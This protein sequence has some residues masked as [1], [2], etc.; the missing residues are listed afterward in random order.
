LGL[1]DVQPVCK[2]IN[3]Y[4]K[5]KF[6]R[7]YAASKLGEDIIFPL[8]GKKGGTPWEDGEQ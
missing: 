5:P 6:M 4:L 8:L 3:P 2:T 1:C 7:R